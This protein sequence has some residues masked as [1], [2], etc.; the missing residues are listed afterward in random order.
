MSSILL[1]RNVFFYVVSKPTS[2][3]IFTPSKSRKTRFSLSDTSILVHMATPTKQNLDGLVTS[4]ELVKEFSE[5]WPVKLARLP[6]YTVRFQFYSVIL[7]EREVFLLSICFW[8]P[9]Q[10]KPK[11]L[12]NNTV[13]SI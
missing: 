10:S 1:S 9:L 3:I 5:I 4:T 12:C 13:K 7:L 8:M 2:S 6:V 11:K